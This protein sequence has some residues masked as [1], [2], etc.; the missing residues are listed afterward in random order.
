MIKKV[1]VEIDEYGIVGKKNITKYETGDGKKF[2][3]ENEAIIHQDKLDREIIINSIKTKESLEHEIP[4]F[5]G[6]WYYFTCEK[7]AKLI[8]QNY[9]KLIYPGWYVAYYEDS[10]SWGQQ[11]LAM[12]KIK[13][14]A[15]VEELLASIPE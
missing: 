8:V 11:T 2:D 15:A 7:E 14:K 13:F 5:T 3:T 1:M 9:D 12:S 6:K 10:Y 4:E